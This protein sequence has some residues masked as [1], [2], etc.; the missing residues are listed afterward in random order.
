MCFIVHEL[1]SDVQTAHGDIECWKVVCIRGGGAISSVYQNFEYERGQTYRLGKPLEKS[2]HHTIYRE[3]VGR[4]FHSY[5]LIERASIERK[6]LAEC[7]I[8][9]TEIIKFV[10][11]QGSQYYYN[12]DSKEYVSTSIFLP[13]EG[14]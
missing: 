9:H 5:C 8:R 4:G 3:E 10:V 7:G 6:E 2:R 13:K 11:P 12:P 1:F 14:E